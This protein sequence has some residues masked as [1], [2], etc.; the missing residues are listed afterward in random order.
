MAEVIK[1]NE[2]AAE[3]FKD[4]KE[5]VKKL[6]RQPCL[7]VVLVG[8]DFASKS[9]VRGKIK[10]GSK[11]NIDVRVFDYEKDVNQELLINK[12]QK[13]N[14]NK[15]IDGIIVQLPLPKHLNESLIINSVDSSKD[16]DGFTFENAGRLFK[17]QPR[18]KPCTPQGIMHMLDK[19]GIEVAKKHVVI[20]GR[21]NLVGLPLSRMMLE[22]DATVTVCHSQTLNLESYTNQA[23][24]LVVA[25]GQKKF[26]KAKHV[27]EDA[28][29]IDVGINRDE[30]NHLAGDVD[31]DE[32]INKVSYITPV[33]KG[34]GPLTISMLLTNTLAAYKG[35]FYE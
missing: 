6:K 27:K 21:S 17:G 5:E 2:I 15:E 11:V 26:I 33:P 35:E 4:I 23:D 19:V 31:F 24:I 14:D 20:V 9:Y 7:A 13:L 10:A 16:V 18:F 1:G 3:I 8:D 28:V 29:I 22:A 30:N 34:V 25:I 12:I 32:V